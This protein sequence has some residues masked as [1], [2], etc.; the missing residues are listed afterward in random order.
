MCFAHVRTTLKRYARTL[1][2]YGRLSI[3]Q[4]DVRRRV[5]VGCA[6]LVDSMNGTNGRRGGGL[7]K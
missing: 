6:E 5:G 2:K 4:A 1:A 7:L 3:V